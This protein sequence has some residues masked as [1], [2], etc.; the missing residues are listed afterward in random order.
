M[1]FTSHARL[2]DAL[3]PALGEAASTI[4]HIRDTGLV[5]EHKSD[6]S[7]VTEA[8]RRA[9]AI[10]SAALRAIHPEFPIAAE[11]SCASGNTPELGR[12][13]FLLDPLDG[14]RDYAIGRNDFTINIGLITDGHPVFGMIYAPA[15]GD[16]FVTTGAGEAVSTK[17]SPNRMPQRLAANET[18]PLRVRIGRSGALTALISQRESGPEFDARLAALGIVARTPV[19]SAIKFGLLARGEADIYPRFGPTCEWDTAAGQAIVET[20]GGTVTAL[21]GTALIYGK[22]STGFLNGPFVARGR[23]TTTR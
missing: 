23:L 2:A 7:P 8:D 10:L 5:V 14:T 20:A 3:L 18:A 13:Y 6:D 16:L 15:H 12:A 11:E 21:D 19:S 22:T 9:E 1:P 4:L 17:L